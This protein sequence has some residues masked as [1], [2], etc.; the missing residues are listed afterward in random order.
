MV[1]M[2]G[3]TSTFKSKYNFLQ[4]Q[5]NCA[6]SNITIII[7]TYW[8]FSAGQFIVLRNFID[9]TTGLCLVAIDVDKVAWLQLKSAQICDIDILYLLL[10][11]VRLNNLRQIWTQLP[12]SV[13]SHRCHVD[14]K[15]QLFICMW[16][17]HQLAAS[18]VLIHIH[19]ASLC[20]GS[21]AFVP[22]IC[23]SLWKWTHLY[24]QSILHPVSFY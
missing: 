23:H 1:H 21:M 14:K 16:P 13:T 22:V 2:V 5:C 10:V 20:T 17:T 6:E 18:S 8:I 4:P 15:S 19:T 9:S 12:S 24:I 11:F 7:K 3:N